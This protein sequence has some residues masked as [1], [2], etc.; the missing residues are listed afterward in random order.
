MWIHVIELAAAMV[1]IHGIF[2]FIINNRVEN[3]IFLLRIF[4]MYKNT[5][6]Y[7]NVYVYVAVEV[8]DLKMGRGWDIGDAVGD[9]NYVE[10]EN[11]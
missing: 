8:Y 7:S 9:E 6:M 5:Y 2:Y 10:D 3:S 1:W 11:P 4:Y